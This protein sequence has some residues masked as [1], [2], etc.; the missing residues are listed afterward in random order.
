MH[1][2]WRRATIPL[3]HNLSAAPL[4]PDPLV[5]EYKSRN[6]QLSEE[7][8]LHNWTGFGNTKSFNRFEVH[9]NDYHDTPKISNKCN[10][11]STL[12]WPPR[13][14]RANEQVS[15]VVVPCS[16]PLVIAEHDSDNDSHTETRSIVR[17]VVSF[18]M[19]C[20]I[21]QLKGQEQTHPSGIEQHFQN[22]MDQ[23]N[24]LVVT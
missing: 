22:K 10:W 1:K 6:L 21:I 14:V 24:V 19:F 12:V 2:L 18:V 7:A 11:K 15:H 3:L 5:T 9:A 4:P 23:Y 16:P 13:P 8:A 17:M 20:D